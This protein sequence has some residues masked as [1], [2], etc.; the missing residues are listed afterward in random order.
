MIFSNYGIKHI[1]G[2]LLNPTG[3]VIIERQNFILKEINNKQ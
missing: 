3:Q 2:I 1:T